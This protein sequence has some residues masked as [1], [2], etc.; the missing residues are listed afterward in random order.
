MAPLEA[1]GGTFPGSA[2]IRKIGRGNT[3]QERKKG[4]NCLLAGDLSP[5][6]VTLALK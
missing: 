6:P 5:E 2:E 3:S 1:K 4:A